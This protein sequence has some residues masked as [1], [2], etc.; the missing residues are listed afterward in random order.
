MVLMVGEIKHIYKGE[1]NMAKTK[2][3]NNKD[4]RKTHFNSFEELREAWGM[5]PPASKAP[6][7][8][9]IE[10]KKKAFLSTCRVCKCPLHYVQGTN[11][12]VCKNAKC[13]GMSIKR[14][15]GSVVIVPISRTLDE[16]GLEIALTLFQ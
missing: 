11:A 7:K 15:D 16:K 13:G 14:K 6:Q 2:A 9:K 4:N 3:K 10:E 1:N 8:N 5:N 12:L